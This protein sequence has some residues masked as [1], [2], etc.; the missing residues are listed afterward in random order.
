[1]VPERPTPLLS[2]C[3]APQLSPAP[4]SLWRSKKE[5]GPWPGENTQR[6]DKSHCEGTVASQDVASL[7][8]QPPEMYKS[9]SGG[10]T[11]KTEPRLAKTPEATESRA[12]EP[13]NLFF[14]GGPRSQH[15][16]M[17]RTRKEGSRT[18][19]ELGSRRKLE[20]TVIS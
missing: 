20:V 7:G 13:L 6:H 2:A 4:S 16:R 3:L 14:L 10:T 17:T 12:T 19:A 1:M 8:E 9:H 18:V 15:T 5:L 11:P